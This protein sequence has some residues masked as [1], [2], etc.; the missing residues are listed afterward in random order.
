MSI[1]TEINRI[2][3]NIANAYTELQ[4]KSATLPTVQNSA[5]LANTISTISSSTVSN[6]TK[7]TANIEDEK[8]TELISNNAIEITLPASKTNI[9]D[10]FKGWSG[11][12]GITIGDNITRLEGR[13]FQNC[14]NLQSLV[15]PN[16]VTS[17]GGY[18]C[19][20]CTGLTTV[21]FGNGL[22]DISAG[23]CL[24][25]SNLTSVTIPRSITRIQVYA[26]YNCT[27]LENVNYLGTKEEWGQINLNLTWKN[28]S[29]ISTITCTDGVIE[30]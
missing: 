18:I 5:N 2:K 3:Q 15:I 6:L 8:L 14:T 17:T 12:T 16:N 23:F 29:S 13:A 27:S 30:V 10:S 26:F 11:L 7:I 4:N 21:S 25:C 1:A 28:N 24:D 20:G 19:N 9:D 22:S